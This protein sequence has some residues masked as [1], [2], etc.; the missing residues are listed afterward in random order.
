M[1]QSLITLL[2]IGYLAPTQAST[3]FEFLFQH[4]NHQKEF[5]LRISA[6]EQDYPLVFEKASLECFHHFKKNNQ[7]ID[8]EESLD[9]IDTCANPVVK[10]AKSP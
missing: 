9:L 1:K 10:T 3:Q 6:P 7:P 2:L 8:E 4:P 5:K